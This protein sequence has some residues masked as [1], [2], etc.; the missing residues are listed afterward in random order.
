MFKKNQNLSLIKQF[1]LNIV[2]ILVFSLGATIITYLFAFILFETINYKNLYPANYYENQIPAI[3]EYIQQK[4]VQLL[5]SSQKENLEHQID[6]NGIKYQ[7]IDEYA[8]FLYGSF[9]E[10]IIQSKQEIYTYLNNLIRFNDEFIRTTPL[11]DQNANIKGAVLLS[12]QIKIQTINQTS[13]LFILILCVALGSPFL[14]MIGFTILFSKKFV[15]NINAPL[16]I[17]ENAAN[18]I[19][20]KNL[21]FEI[22]YQSENELGKLANAFSEMKEALKN[23]LEKQWKME[24]DRIEMVESLAHDLKTPLSILQMYAEALEEDSLE[25][26]EKKQRYLQVLQENIQKSIYYVKQMQYTSELD[27]F[28]S[29]VNLAPVNLKQFILQKTNNYQL[30]FQQAQINFTCRFEGDFK[31]NLSLNANNLERILNNLLE[32]SLSH[33]PQGGEILLDVKNQNQTIYYQL[34]DTGVGFSEKDIEKG[35]EK[36]YRGDYARTNKNNNIGLGLFIAKK[37]IEQMGGGIELSNN[38]QG[39]ACVNFWHPL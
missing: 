39:G 1:Q 27:T 3:E 37:L 21:D 14:Y 22:N 35:F 4:N 23:S 32:N 24:Q 5:N 9:S 17:L 38:P 25:D 31:T 18:N 15:N 13:W 26:V 19:K 30:K 20:E 11:L 2:R 7:V 10:P 34:T 36:F 16:S 33:T 28:D 12:Y 8:E 29:Q 6:P